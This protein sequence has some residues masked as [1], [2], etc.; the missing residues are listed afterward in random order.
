M[1]PAEG[2]TPAHVKVSVDPRRLAPANYSAQLV[3]TT[4]SAASAH[5][6][7]KVA[8]AAPVTPPSSVISQKDAKSTPV[9]TKP[10]IPSQPDATQTASARLPTNEPAASQP[11]PGPKPE[12][13]PAQPLPEL[14]DCNASNYHRKR[15]GTLVWEGSLEPEG[16]LVIGGPYPALAGGKITDGEFPGCEI[17]FKS[18]TSGI[19]IDEM[20]TKP[21]HFSRVKL[22][23]SSTKRLSLIQLNWT[24]EKK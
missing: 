24:S 4:D 5:T 23:N 11:N 6:N 14:V 19:M 12:A 17:S 1:E 21:D 15:N 2:V 13:V 7:V 18:Y 8:V 20:P 3:F 10:G 22:H 9:Q 16:V